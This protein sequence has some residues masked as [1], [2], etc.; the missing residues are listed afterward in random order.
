M[1]QKMGGWGVEGIPPHTLLPPCSCKKIE[2][3]SAALLGQS[4]P[5]QNTPF[6][7]TCLPRPCLQASRRRRGAR[8]LTIL[9]F[10]LTAIQL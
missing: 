10:S 8:T 4:R 7:F 2:V 1:G 6:L 3:S 9:S 5:K